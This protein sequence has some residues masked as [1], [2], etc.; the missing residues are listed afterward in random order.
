MQ[1]YVTR[2]N[3]VYNV[4]PQNLR[5]PPDSVLIKFPDGFDSNIAYQLRE[6]APQTLEEMQNIVVS[7]EANLIEK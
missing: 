1:D 5:N 6:R 2:F 3:E 4:V 7:V